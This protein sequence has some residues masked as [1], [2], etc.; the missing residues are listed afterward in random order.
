MQSN[1]LNLACSEN[2]S[3]SI[4]DESYSSNDSTSTPVINES[5]FG[6]R[7]D[8]SSCPCI[9][10]VVLASAS[11]TIMQVSRLSSLFAL[12]HCTRNINIIVHGQFESNLR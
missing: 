11:P 9:D 3:D 5:D 4:D 6:W 2:L 1:G 10:G 7:F 8:A 12:I